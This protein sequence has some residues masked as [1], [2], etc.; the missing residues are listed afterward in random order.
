MEKK[1]L[2]LIDEYRGF[3]IIYMIIYHAIWD[4]VYIF[5]CD[6]QWFKSDMAFICQQVGCWSFIFIS[7]F[8]WQM[9][10]HNRKRGLEVFGAGV[11]IT[12]ATLIFMPDSRVLFG[13]LTMLGSSML[14]MIPCNK[15]LKKVNPWIGAVVS[16]MIFLF[17]YPVNDG[18]LGFLGIE[19][20]DVPR[21]LYS[22]WLSTYL[23]FP[24]T[25]FWSTDYFSILPWFFL[26]VTGYFGYSIVFCGKEG[27]GKVFTKALMA[28][29]ICPPLGWIGRNSL[30]IYML[31]QPVV[32]GILMVWNMLR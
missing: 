18:Y 30:I 17:V 21:T 15:V 11:V 20:V 3:W 7:G 2:H 16:F 27:R 4:L 28:K 14:R 12:V 6:W 25:G 8:C 19:M 31:H 22:D 32:Y 10:R 26:Y 5:N 23:G 9:S 1:R 24:M 13:V 29:S